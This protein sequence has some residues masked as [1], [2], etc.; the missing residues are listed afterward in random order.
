[1][2]VRRARVGKKKHAWVKW[3]VAL[4]VVAF[5]GLVFA[6]SVGV[7][8]WMR[9][10]AEQ[11]SANQEQQSVQVPEQEIFP[12]S[13]SPIKASKYRIGGRYNSYLNAGIR[14]LCAPLR[15]SEGT[16]TY[17]SEV[18]AHAG[19]DRNGSVNL[20]TNAWELH[21]NGMYL[22]TYIEITGFAQ[23]NQAVRELMLSYE[24]SLVAEAAASGVDEIFLVGVSPTQASVTEIAQYVRRVK[25][26]AG[27]CAI[28][29]MITPDV[30]LAAEYEVYMAAQLL[31]VCDFLVLDLRNIPLE[32][33]APDTETQSTSEAQTQPPIPGYANQQEMTVKYLM[34]HMQYD[35]VRYSPRLAL[36]EQQS[37][38]LDYIISKGYGNWVIVE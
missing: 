16:L 34:E 12:V 22:S 36:G 25:S 31:S 19:W 21:Q 28:G 23:E 29:V 37:D 26:L 13:V 3:V 8:S 14:H 9:E 35:L 30:L 20:E 38:A 4:G 11:Y 2:A 33:A 7:G 6:A 5:L 17:A 15:D 27:D 32:T 10:Q 18:C 24:A 1:M